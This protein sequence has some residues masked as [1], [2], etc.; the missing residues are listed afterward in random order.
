MDASEDRVWKSARTGAAAV[1][2]R[3]DQ[4]RKAKQLCEQ[5]L[6]RFPGDPYAFNVL[7]GCL[8]DLGDTENAKKAFFAAERARSWGGHL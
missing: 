2:R 4:S 1:L 5:V 6:E 7:A 8:A 3:M